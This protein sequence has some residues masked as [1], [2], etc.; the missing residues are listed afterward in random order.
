MTAYMKKIRLYILLVWLTVQH[1]ALAQVCLTV[2]APYL[3]VQDTLELW[4]RKDY[5]GYDYNGKY[6]LLKAHNE[7]GK[8]HFDFDLDGLSWMSLYLDYQKGKGHPMH[9][10]IEKFLVAD[11]DSLTL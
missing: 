10:I 8:Y 4:L 1:I 2:D 3:S 7:N 11:G 9:G 6:A 5:I